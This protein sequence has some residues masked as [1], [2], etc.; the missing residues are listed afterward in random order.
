VVVRV[1]P[2]AGRDDAY[3]TLFIGNSFSFY[4]GTVGYRQ[5]QRRARSTRRE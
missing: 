5:A 1:C 4:N 3:K 2:A